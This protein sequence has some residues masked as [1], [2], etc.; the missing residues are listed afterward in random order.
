MGGLKFGSNNYEYNMI[1]SAK[2]MC[3]Y[4]DLVEDSLNFND[5]FQIW[6]RSLNS[7]DLELIEHDQESRKVKQVAKYTGKALGFF[8]GLIFGYASISKSP[9]KEIA[10]HASFDRDV[11]LY[12]I[13]NGITY[14]SLRKIL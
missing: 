13:E 1:E 10:E 4:K 5:A 3:Q 9:T 11:W 7:E 6:Y 14:K 12:L 2:L 8:A